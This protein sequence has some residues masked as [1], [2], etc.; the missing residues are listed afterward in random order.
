MSLGWKS[1]AF[2]DMG[3]HE[4]HF[5]PIS[6]HE[7]TR[8]FIGVTNPLVTNSDAAEHLVGG[9]ITAKGALF[10]FSFWFILSSSLQFVRG[11]IMDSLNQFLLLFGSPS[12]VILLSFVVV[13]TLENVRTSNQ[14]WS[15]K[16]ITNR[17]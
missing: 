2:G 8:G 13:H 9:P 3:S 14:N 4:L 1:L 17:F 5:A 7:F 15:A 16:R 10:I 6:R 12:I 11:V